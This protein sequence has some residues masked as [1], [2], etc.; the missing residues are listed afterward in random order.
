METRLRI[1]ASQFPVS[2]DVGRNFRHISK[3]ITVAASS[4]AD[5]ILFPETALPGYA[6]RHYPDARTYDWATIH[7]YQLRIAEL[8]RTQGIWVVLGTVRQKDQDFPRNC[9]QVISPRGVVVATYEKRR[10]HGK[11]RRYFSAGS[12]PTVVEISGVLCGFL[13]CYDNCFPELYTEYRE[14]GVEVVFHS[15]FN[16]GN[17]KAT[18]IKDLMVAN[19]MVRAADN[20]FWIAASNSSE[21]YS[22]LAACIVRPDG[23]MVQ[24]KRHQASIVMDQ[25]P[26][27]ELGWTYDNRYV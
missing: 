15:F 23:S 19:L 7:E 11:E 2:E 8:A 3:H 25:F 13:V 4:S 6:P 16:A 17:A 14:L 26:S 1:A 10:L 18:S 12:T 9:L 21:T 27:A 24:S 20:G 5:I 22:P